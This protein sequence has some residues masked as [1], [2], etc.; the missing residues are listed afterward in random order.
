M[1]KGRKER[2]KG[3][4]AL[5]SYFFFLATCIL[6]WT[7]ETERQKQENS[8]FLKITHTPQKKPTK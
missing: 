4:K 1:L 2:Q 5:L 6:L 3:G 7:K 8:D